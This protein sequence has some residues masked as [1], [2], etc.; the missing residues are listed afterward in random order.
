[1]LLDTCLSYQQNPGS[2]YRFVPV[3][4]EACTWRC[5]T[6]DKTRY[7]TLCSHVKWP[8]QELASKNKACRWYYGP[9]SHPKK[10][11]KYAWQGIREIHEYCISDRMKL[12][13][14]KCKEM[15][16]NFMANPNTVMR[17]TCIGNHVAACL[18]KFVFYY[19]VLVVVGLGQM[20]GYWVTYT[21]HLSRSHS[22][23]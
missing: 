12:N 11:Y 20:A 4:L 22:D 13:P 6:G 10:F 21:L 1:M 23:C 7:N 5:P 9:W 17:P 3:I 14:K 18:S 15:D 2:A 8:T 16:I 19:V